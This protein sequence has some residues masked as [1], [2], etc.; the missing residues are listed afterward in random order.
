[1]KASKQLILFKYNINFPTY[2]SEGQG[3]EKVNAGSF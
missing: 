2:Q 3:R 1:M